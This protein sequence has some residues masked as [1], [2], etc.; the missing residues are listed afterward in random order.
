MKRIVGFALGM[1]TGTLL[2]TQFLSKAHQLDRGRA[3][4]IGVFVGL[5]G[6]NLRAHLATEEP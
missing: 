2:Y 1:A 6:R 5:G 3:A 4:F